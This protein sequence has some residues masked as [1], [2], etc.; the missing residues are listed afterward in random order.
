MR[1]KGSPAE[2][3]HRR[4]LA[5]QRILDGYSI[6]EVADFLGID[7]RSVRRWVAAFRDQGTAGLA[8]QPVPGRPPK[9]S[10]TQEKVVFRWL[11]ANPTEHGFASELWTTPQLAEV[12]REEWGVSFRPEYLTV[13]LRKRGLTPQKP[14]RLARERDPQKIA[15]WLAEDWPRIKKTPDGTTPTSPSSMRADC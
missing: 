13:W 6:E 8:A 5:I 11:S 7:V 4:L 2:L 15:T 14:R 3:E 9:L 12:I 10:T 1:S